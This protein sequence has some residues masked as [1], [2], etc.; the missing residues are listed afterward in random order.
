M[1]PS[2]TEG[3]HQDTGLHIV[4]FISDVKR[5]KLTCLEFFIITLKKLN[6]L[7][8]RNVFC[9]H[10]HFEESYDVSR[11]FVTLYLNMFDKEQARTHAHLRM[12]SESLR[13]ITE[14]N[15]PLQPASRGSKIMYSSVWRLSVELS[16]SYRPNIEIRLPNSRINQASLWY[17]PSCRPLKTSFNPL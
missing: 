2:E 8:H 10:L 1:S 14:H 7:L 5:D 16:A 11:H 3:H 12:G 9:C 15:T 17:E 4:V 13:R 6:F